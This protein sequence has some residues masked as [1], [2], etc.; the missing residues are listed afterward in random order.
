MSKK[1]LARATKTVLKAE[2]FNL[3][4]P[5][6]VTISG[7]L[8]PTGRL[9]EVYPFP[10]MEGIKEANRAA[11]LY[12]FTPEAMG[13]F[14]SYIKKHLGKGVFVSSE[15]NPAGTNY[16]TVRVADSVGNI[17]TFGTFPGFEDSLDATVAAK[18]LKDLLSLGFYVSDGYGKTFFLSR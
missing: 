6:A 17:E 2:T 15:T 3:G 11:G 18:T 13:F 5:C 8:A 9:I 12:W 10:S 4:K 1:T 7:D 16:C 14:K